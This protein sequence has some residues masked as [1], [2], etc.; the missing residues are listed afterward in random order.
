LNCKFI[1]K[2]RPEAVFDC[3]LQ[4]A[5]QF[6]RDSSI[7]SNLGYTPAC[8]FHCARYI[9]SFVNNPFEPS[10]WR[11]FGS[12]DREH[13]M[14][15]NINIGAQR[16]EPDFSGNAE[17]LAPPTNQE[18]ASSQPEVSGHPRSPPGL[19][20]QQTTFAMASATR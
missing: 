14:A 18:E 12:A 17:E 10:K 4:I 3:Q 5:S 6:R 9:C 13:V 2:I 8:Q 15:A 20:Q 19:L 11:V 16:H 7:S 1:G